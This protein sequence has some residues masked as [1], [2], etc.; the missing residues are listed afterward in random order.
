M[1]NIDKIKDDLNRALIWFN[2]SQMTKQTLIRLDDYVAFVLVQLF[3]EKTNFILDRML[4]EL[5]IFLEEYV[6]DD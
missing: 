4:D 5:R 3:K 1:L 2:I 6:S